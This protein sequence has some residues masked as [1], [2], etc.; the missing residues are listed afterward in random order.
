MPFAE[1]HGARIA[2]SATG[3]TEADEPGEPALLIMG[4]A[5]SSRAW[6]RLL[7]H[8]APRYRAIAFDNR[9]TGASDA[10][11]GPLTMDDLVGAGIAVLDDAGVEAAHVIG[12]SM[13]GMIA[14]HMALDHRQRVRSLVLGCTA[15]GGRSGPPPWR[16]LLA[17][18]AGTAIGPARRFALTA[19]LLYA[20]RTLR[21]HHDR[22]RDDFEVRFADAT[23]PVTAWAQ[24]AAVA[25][26]DTSARLAQL[27]GL[28][29]LVLH[30]AEDRLVDPTRGVELASAI[31]GARYVELPSCGHMLTTDAEEATA[32]AILDF[33]ECCGAR[34]S[35]PA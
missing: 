5:G 14:Q 28:P 11:R 21:E 9:G 10:V 8:L 23:S 18:A 12:V 15:S 30:G 3:P 20:P 2:W 19:P 6:W 26:H 34:A 13:G 22:L 17:N 33:L 16:L 31:P 32:E 7:K 24:L 25:R 35:Q 4:L 1:Y 27:E 29:T